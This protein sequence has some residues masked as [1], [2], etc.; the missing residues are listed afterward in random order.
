MEENEVVV[1]EPTDTG[2]VAATVKARADVEL[3]TPE[4]TQAILTG[5]MNDIANILTGDGLADPTMKEC[6]KCKKEGRTSYHP[7]ESF[8]ML[9]TGKYSSQCKRCKAIA[10]NA[11]CASKAE[12]R[13]E[14]HRKYREGRK[15]GA[16]TSKAVK[17]LQAA[18]KPAEVVPAPDVDYPDHI[19]GRK[20]LETLYAAFHKTEAKEVLGN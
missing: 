7:I 15:G 1:V 3:I 10:A 20:H 14:Y 8:S 4:V 5:R 19:K 11:W 17:T 18:Q 6:S 2:A 12:H 13:K 16:S 9:K